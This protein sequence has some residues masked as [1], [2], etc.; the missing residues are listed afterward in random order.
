M[1][2]LFNELSSLPPQIL[3]RWPLALPLPVLEQCSGR[4]GLERRA[5]MGEHDQTATARG[6]TFYESLL[7]CINEVIA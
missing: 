6:L 3:T 7:P 5:R 2:A 4:R 1:R